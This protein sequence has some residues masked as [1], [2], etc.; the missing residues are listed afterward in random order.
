[1]LKFHTRSAIRHVRLQG[2][3]VGETK[4]AEYLNQETG[5][6]ILT[7]KRREKN[8]RQDFWRFAACRKI[9]YASNRNLTGSGTSFRTGKLVYQ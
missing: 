6:V 3:Y 7:E 2:L 5:T 4:D 8:E 1:M 9:L